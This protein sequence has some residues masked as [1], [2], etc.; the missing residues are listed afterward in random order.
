MNNKLSKNLF[1]DEM[2]LSMEFLP[3]P[4]KI[5]NRYG[6]NYEV[7]RDLQSDPHVWSCIQSRKGGLL[8]MEYQISRS[9][10]KENQLL[11]DE[12]FKNNDINKLIREILD[13]IY[14]GYSIIEIIW[15]DGVKGLLPKSFLSRPQEW[16]SFSPDGDVYYTRGVNKQK[17]DNYKILLVNNESGL[18]NPYGNALLS[19]VYWSVKFKNSGLKYWVRYMEK[20][21]LPVLLGQYKRGAKGEEIQNLLDSLVEMNEDSVIVTPSDIDIKINESK[22][23]SS[24]ELY[25]GLI[26]FCNNEISKAL[27][28]QTLTTELKSGSLAASQTHFQIRKELIDADVRLVEHSI[29]ELIKKIIDLNSANK[30]Y[31]EFKYLQNDAESFARLQRDKILSDS[32]NI[33]FNKNYWQKHYGLDENEFELERNE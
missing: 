22:S 8:S 25:S 27:L 4:D 30:E 21:G 33:M 18:N 17:V 19:K 3:N 12:F 6:K 2:L 26:D 23:N 1:K 32:T 29:N 7:L 15:E 31:P 28:S 10:N 16:F 11:I 24:I 5:I 9:S 13:S 14:F 20:Y